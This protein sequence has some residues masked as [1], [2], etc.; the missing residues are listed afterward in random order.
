MSNS[1]IKRVLDGLLLK[2]RG[3]LIYIGAHWSIV[4]RR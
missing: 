1:L 2:K 4:I 3:N